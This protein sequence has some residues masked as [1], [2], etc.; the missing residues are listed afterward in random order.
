MVRKGEMVMGD[1]GVA[2]VEIQPVS[3]ERWREASWEEE[4]KERMHACLCMAFSRPS[5][6]T[7][8]ASWVRTHL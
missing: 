4:E 1:K 5:A 7:E 6:C 2:K 8:V 3:S